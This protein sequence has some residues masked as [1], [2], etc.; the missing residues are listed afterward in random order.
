[1]NPDNVLVF[2]H[3]AMMAQWVADRVPHARRGFGPARAIGVAGGTEEKPRMLAAIVYH[4]YQPEAATMQISMASES[5]LW[6][7]PA[8]IAALLH[9]PFMQQ[10]CYKVWTAIP[11]DNER[12]VRFNKGIG[13]RSEATLRHH[14]GHKRHALIFSMTRPEYDARWRVGV[15]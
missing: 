10:N 9:F 14:F 12:A 6:A 7:K 1:M 5:P 3:D 2:G 4:D 8:T 15:S 13:M 11:S